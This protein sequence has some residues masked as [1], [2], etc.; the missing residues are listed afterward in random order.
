MDCSEYM[1]VIVPIRAVYYYYYFSLLTVVMNVSFSRSSITVSEEEGC[2]E[3][4]LL[5]SE[6]GV[7]PVTVTVIPLP[8]SAESECD[9]EIPYSAKISRRTIFAFFADWSGTVKIRHCEKV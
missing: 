3:L 1:S 6:N 7:G 5:K 8:G 9:R 2:V 4:T